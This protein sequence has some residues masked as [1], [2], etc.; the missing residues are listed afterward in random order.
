MRTDAHWERV[1][2]R[3]HHGI[4][5]SL[6]SLR[7]KKSCGIGDF[8][9][10][11]PLIDWCKEVGF[12]CIQLLPL[13]DSG[14]DPSPYNALSSCALDPI[15]LSLSDL[16]EACS[17]LSSLPRTNHLETRREKKRWLRS[18]FSRTFASIKTQPEYLDF[19]AKNSWLHPYALFKACKQEHN[20]A[21]WTE[22]PKSQ[23]SL[24]TCRAKDPADLDFYCF[25]Q[26]L[27]F[28]QME[29][30]RRYADENGILLKGDIP[31][32]ISPDSVDVWSHPSLFDISYGAGAPPDYY[33]QKGQAWGFPLYR[34]DQMRKTHFQWWKERLRVAE[35]FYHLYRI[36]HVVGFF[37]IWAIEPKKKASTG[38]FIPQDENEWGPQGR[39]LL[40]MM[41]DSSSMLPMAEDLGTIPEITFSTLRELGICGTKV[42]RWQRRWNSDRAFIPYNEYD[43]VSMTTVSTPDSGTLSYWWKQFPEDGKEFAKFKNWTYS[44]TL[45]PEQAKEILRD[46]HHTPS[47]FHINQLQEYLALFPSLV[48]RNPEE[49][50]LNTPGTEL[51]TNWTYRFL[52]DLEEI[53]ENREL[54]LAI[55][56]LL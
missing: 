29:T 47:F 9:A 2:M 51:P 30:V 45:S 32:L 28:Q 44:P 55:Q 8:G 49:E 53:M 20:H 48:R 24:A 46:S 19:L 11:L 27:A 56:S 33:N 5:L 37:R 25:L 54:A 21:S 52:P 15:Y 38:H 7:T 26:Y 50:R 34:W 12:D 4:C 35:R 43:P 13:N 22:W 3:P 16:P 31:I 6:A 40:E 23:Q 10:L 36:D 14:D 17:S 39:E 1:G 18:Y 42:I 41:I